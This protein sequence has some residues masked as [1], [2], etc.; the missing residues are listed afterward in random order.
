MSP[1]VQAAIVKAAS[2]WAMF[3]STKPTEKPLFGKGSKGSK[4]QLQANFQD[5]YKAIHDFLE[6]SA[7][8]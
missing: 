1:E 3:L 5:S 6:S 2:D 4:P 7:Q 8:L